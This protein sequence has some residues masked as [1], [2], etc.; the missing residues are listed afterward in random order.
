LI[1]AGETITE[2]RGRAGSDARHD[3]PG[4][5]CRH[6]GAAST[7]PP[8]RTTR[9]VSGVAPRVVEV[10][11]VHEAGRPRAGRRPLQTRRGRSE[12]PSTWRERDGELIV[13]ITNGTTRFETVPWP[14]R[15]EDARAPRVRKCGDDRQGRARPEYLTGAGGTEACRPRIVTAGCAPGGDKGSDDV[16]SSFE[17]LDATWCP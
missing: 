17:A 4:L 3:D 1:A 5:R 14:G 11:C 9:R 2:R 7:T 10:V 16:S 13:T 6:A 8:R 15:L 12:T